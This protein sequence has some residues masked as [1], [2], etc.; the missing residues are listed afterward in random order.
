MDGLSLLPARKAPWPG[1]GGTIPFP[2]ESRSPAQMKADNAMSMILNEI[3]PEPIAQALQKATNAH[4]EICV[5]TDIGNDGRFG[6][7]WLVVTDADVMVFSNGNGALL[8]KRLL[9]SDLLEVKTQSL[10]GGSAL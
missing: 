9:L 6:E 4:V 2:W 10:I 5:A 8:E 3:I 7:Q 1:Y